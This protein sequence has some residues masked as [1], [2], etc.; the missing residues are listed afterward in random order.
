MFLMGASGFEYKILFARKG[1]TV[2]HAEHIVDPLDKREKLLMFD[3][4]TSFSAILYDIGKR[5]IEFEFK[6]P[7]STVANPH[8]GFM[9]ME[10]IPGFGNAGDIVC[11]D[12][13]N[14]IIVIDRRKGEVR[15]RKP[16]PWKPVWVH[17]V[18]AGI[19][20]KSIIVTDYQVTNQ[21]TPRVSKLLL[22][23]LKE[24]WARTDIPY[25]AKISRIEGAKLY[26]DPSFG[27]EYLVT[28]NHL[29][30]YTG[31]GAVHELRDSDGSTVW[32][33]PDNELKGAWLGTPHSA[34]RIGRVEANGNLTIIG[35]E[36]GG[37]I[38]AVDYSGQPVWGINSIFLRRRDGSW[39]YYYNPYNLAEVTHV[40]PTLNGRIG[41]TAWSGLNSSIV[42][43]IIRIPRKQTV[44]YVLAYNKAS[45]DTL[46]FLEPIVAN[47]WDEI[48]IGVQN[49]GN[50]PLNLV[51]KGYM[52][53]QLDLHGRPGFGAFT[54]VSTTLEAGGEKEIHLTRPYAFYEIGVKSAS[55]GLS[56]TYNILVTKK[57]T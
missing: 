14:N 29:P 49:T 53:P 19:D 22:P 23:D 12:R 46:T 55:P 39:Q 5:E 36:S 11:T 33:V 10:D 8:Q 21:Q 20:G 25:P 54:I 6:V 52:T 1:Y 32:R 2:H 30:P 34:F 41:F 27:G 7:G 40:F 45:T 24:V 50:H 37:G 9:L 16:V 57:R 38:V 56:T 26:P 3:P 47:D 51:V 4:W 42:G 31:L 43:E 13:D 15:L 48:L 18:T 35:G 44:F 17:C 28:S